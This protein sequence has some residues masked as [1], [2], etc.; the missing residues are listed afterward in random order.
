M[1]RVYNGI[2]LGVQLSILLLWSCAEVKPLDQLPNYESLLLSPRQGEANASDLELL[3]RY[4][5]SVT[6]LSEEKLQREF[7]YAW[8]AAAIEPTG[9]DRLRLILLLSLPGSPTQDPDQARAMLQSFLKT[10]AAPGLHDLALLL[11]EFLLEE[12]RQQRR[13]RLLQ[14]KFEQKD[15][16]VKRLK[17]GL[18]YLNG[19]RKL[20]QEWAETLEQQLAD[21][22]GRAETLEQKL[23]ALK[24]IEKK[25]EYRNQPEQSLELPEQ[26]KE[27]DD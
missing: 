8:Q 15:E 27:L 10:E 6:T 25:L 1:R 3:L 22:R 23:E 5:H 11:Q 24:S 4:Y 17:S 7:A 2:V 20:E 16:Q 21:E 13:Y 26:S 9:F 19:H 12:A 14:E 18:K